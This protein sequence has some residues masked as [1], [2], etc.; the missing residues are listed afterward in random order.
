[1]TKGVWSVAGYGVVTA[2]GENRN[3]EPVGGVVPDEE[4]L[5]AQ[6]SRAAVT[7]GVCCCTSAFSQQSMPSSIP[8]I[9]HPCLPECRGIPTTALPPSTKSMNKEISRFAI[10]VILVKNLKVSQ[11][12]SRMQFWQFQSQFT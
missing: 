3:C 10:K 12:Y 6:Q 4:Q 9:L 1:M 5:K 7:S 11:G 8:G 2:S